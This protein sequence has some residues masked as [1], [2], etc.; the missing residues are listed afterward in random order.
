[1]RKRDL[2]M[3]ELLARCAEVVTS[4][5]R[6][7]VAQLERNRVEVVEGEACLVDEHTLQVDGSSSRVLTADYIVIATGTVASRP[8]SVPFADGMIVDA[9]GLPTFTNLPHSFIVVGAGV[10]GT[11]YASMFALLDIEVTL[12]D[13]KP[14]MLDFVDPEIAE[15]LSYHMRDIGVM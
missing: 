15:A 6:V 10:I 7:V 2:T 14:G 5:T 11:E 13:Q 4:E 3:Q 1:R 12:I 9:S 8:E